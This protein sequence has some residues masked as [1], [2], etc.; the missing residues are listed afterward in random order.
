MQVQVNKLMDKLNSCTP[1][2]IRCVKPNNSKKPYD[3]VEAY[4]LLCAEIHKSEDVSALLVAATDDM[5]QRT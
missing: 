1:N 5:R 3:I 2:Y 4:V